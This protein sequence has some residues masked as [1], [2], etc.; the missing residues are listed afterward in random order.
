MGRTAAI[1]IEFPHRVRFTRDALDPANTSIAEVFREAGDRPARVLTFLDTHVGAAMPALPDHLRRYAA[2][3]AGGMSL[4]DRVQ[5]VVGGEACKNDRDA[6]YRVLEAIDRNRIDRHSYVLVIGGG[7]VLDCVGFAAAIAHRGVRLV[8]MPTTTLAQADSGVGVKNGINGFGK[9]N[10]LGTFAVPWA[11]VNDARFLETLPDREWRSGFVEAVKVALVKDAALFDDVERVA[12]LL[13]ARRMD[14]AV[15]I[16]R[17]SAELHLRHIATGGDPFELT[18]AR[19]L[20]FGHWAAHKLEATT[21]YALGHGEAVAVGV[22]LDATY[23]HLAGLLDAAS[24]E[25]VLTCLRALGFT[26]WHEAMRDTK[27]LLAG[28]EEFREH[29]GGELTV[30]MLAGIGRGVDVHRVDAALVD[31]SVARLAALSPAAAMR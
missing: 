25:R 18:T 29:L 17:R 9:K 13:A 27:T 8:R 14:V 15:P 16:I 5:P 21:G 19:P 23:S 6:V 7:A 20:D 2:A 1:Q 12:P 3:H 28:L 30:T 10:F 11:V 31:R 26:L 24:L 4:V 22:A